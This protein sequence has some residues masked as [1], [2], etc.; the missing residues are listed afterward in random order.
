LLRIASPASFFSRDPLF[1]AERDLHLLS[2][3]WTVFRLGP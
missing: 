3:A 2:T 1:A